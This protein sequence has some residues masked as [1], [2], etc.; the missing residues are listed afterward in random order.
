MV[1][2]NKL[3]KTGSGI[4]KD[5]FLYRSAVGALQYA[6]ITRPN[7]SFA[8]N[9]VRQ[10]MAQPLDTH[11][12]AVKR[13]LRYLKGTISWGI[14][15]KPI[16]IGPVSLSAYCDVDWGSD[17]NDRRRSTTGACV[18]LLPREQPCVLVG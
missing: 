13:I 12:V 10:F 8:V 4:F 6:T 9:N 11:W 15:L 17:T 3:S 1:A 2:G 18:F 16:T 7:I 14:H 5:P